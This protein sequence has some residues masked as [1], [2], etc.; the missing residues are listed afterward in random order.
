MGRALTTER[1][2]QIEAAAGF[3]CS[4][5]EVAAIAGVDVAALDRP[6]VRRAIET[7]RAAVGSRVAAVLIRKALEGNVP[8]CIFYLKARHG[9]RDTDAALEREAE[10]RAKRVP[11]VLIIE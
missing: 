8:A 5:A 6:K 10:E 2:R 3:G 9:W 7:A 4:D 1:M 11:R